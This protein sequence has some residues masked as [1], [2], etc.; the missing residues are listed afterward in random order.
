MAI[1]GLLD[2]Y[3]CIIIDASYILVLFMVD[4]SIQMLKNHMIA[5]V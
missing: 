4:H 1:V 3:E 2:T 5:D